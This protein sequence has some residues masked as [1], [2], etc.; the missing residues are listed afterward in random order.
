VTAVALFDRVDNDHDLDTVGPTPSVTVE[1]PVDGAGDAEELPAPPL[2]VRGDAALVWTGTELVVWGGDVEA[3]NMGLPGEDRSFNDGAAYDPAARSWRTMSPGPLRVGT[4]TPVGAMTDEGVVLVRATATALW[5]PVT[6]TWRELERAPRPVED[7]VATGGSAVSYSANARLDLDAGRWVD[8]PAPPLRLERPTTAWTGDDLIVVGG[9]G[10]AFT[11][12]QAIAYNVADDAWRTLAPPP[13]DLHAEALAAAW[14]D[15]RVVVVNY[16]MRAVAYDPVTDAWRDLPHVPAR[17]SEW[18]P[19]LQAGGGISVATMA[20]AVV[21]LGTDDRWIPL[22]T[23]GFGAARLVSSGSALFAWDVDT[24][25]EINVLR[26]IDPVRTAA[27]PTAAQVG[28]GQVPVPQGFTIVETSYSPT[29]VVTLTMEGPTGSC[30]VTSSYLGMVGPDPDLP[31]EDRFVVGGRVTS[32]FHAEDERVWRTAATTSDLVEIA[33][34]EGPT[35]RALAS[36][37]IVPDPQ[38]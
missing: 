18:Q 12:A 20:A 30:T 36:E 38:L 22:P 13:S 2:E 9:P 35:A 21:V 29:D 24:E 17:F 5:N 6:D 26:T 14:D 25:R 23:A 19:S 7:L 11:S 10:S 27:A 1:L 28:L 3:A 32:W 37:T 16:D 15:T 33:C 31:V 8:L 4:S 34:D